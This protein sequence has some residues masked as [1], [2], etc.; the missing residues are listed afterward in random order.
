M[1]PKKKIWLLLIVSLICS[2]GMLWAGGG[3]EAA[4]P[5]ATMGEGFDWQRFEGTR[6]VINWSPNQANN[7]INAN[8]GEFEALTGMKVEVDQIDYMRMHDKQVLEMTK[9]TGDYDLIS[10]VVMWKT[11]YVDGDMLTELEPLFADSNLAVPGY[12]FDDLVKAFVDNTG[13]VG[14]EKIYMGGPGSKLYCVP[15]GAETSLMAYRKDVLD[16]TGVAVPKTYDELWAAFPKVVD[17]NNKVYA[18]TMRGASGHQATHGFLNHLNPTGGKVFDKDWNPIVNSPEALRALAFQ[19]EAVKYGAPGIP[20][21]EAGSMDESFLQGQAVFYIDHDKIAGLA[22]DPAQSKVDGKVGYALHPK[23]K[24]YS[25]ETGGFGIGIP[26]NSANKEA[27]FLLMQWATTKEMGVRVA[28][29]GG[30]AVRNSVYGDPQLQ[31]KYPEFKVLVEQIKYADPDWRPIIPEWGEINQTIGVAVNQVLTGEKSAK[32]AMDGII[33]PIRDIM[34][35]AGY[36]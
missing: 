12:D 20:G 1:M 6:L 8:I 35:R 23:D 28:E 22:R 29:A 33:Q 13:R 26:A 21:F 10:L 25:A 14:G 32:A 5:S 2:A 15:F 16:A 31:A 17:P 9:P 36:Y 27:A 18:F 7:Y 30:M 24:I 34:Q 3:Q 11:E 19:K 4:K